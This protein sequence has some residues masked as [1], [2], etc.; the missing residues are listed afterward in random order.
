MYSK[1]P[2]E[3]HPS[4]SM[5]SRR[6]PMP[7]PQAASMERPALRSDDVDTEPPVPVPS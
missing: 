6:R 2:S 3:A 1:T 4:G 7:V 5:P